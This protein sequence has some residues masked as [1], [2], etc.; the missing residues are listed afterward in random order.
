MRVRIVRIYLE[1]SP[2]DETLDGVNFVLDLS[3]TL[4]R[5]LVDLV[6]EQ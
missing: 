1:Q 4:I 5:T 2:L 3:V 6:H